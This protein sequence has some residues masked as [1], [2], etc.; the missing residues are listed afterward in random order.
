MQGQA[1]ELREGEKTGAAR[2]S[3]QST[4]GR[5]GKA[6]RGR[7]A[8]R[9][10]GHHEDVWRWGLTIV[11][12]VVRLGVVVSASVWVTPRARGVLV[13]AKVI[14]VMRPFCSAIE[15][16]MIMCFV[17]GDRENSITLTIVAIILAMS[18][19]YAKVIRAVVP[20]VVALSRSVIM[21]PIEEQGLLVRT[22]LL[23]GSS[24]RLVMYSDVA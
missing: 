3:G 15:V 1:N 21:S 11:A 23:A 8:G 4:R 19:S 14:I 18:T 17:C 24:L 20:C 7:G 5:R 2:A 9:A 6:P 16:P 22:P 10:D 13:V 12:R